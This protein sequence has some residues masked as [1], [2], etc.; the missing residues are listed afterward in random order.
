LFAL[1]FARVLP[2][3]W[4]MARHDPAPAAL[5]SADVVTRSDAEGRVIQISGAWTRQNLGPLRE[6]FAQAALAGTDVRLEMEHVTYADSAFVGLLLL[7]QGHLARAGR[8]LR[9]ASHSAAARRVLHYC[10]AEQLC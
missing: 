10:C 4:Y 3:A 8:Q 1:L 7:L 5:A 9:I 2:Y 6:C